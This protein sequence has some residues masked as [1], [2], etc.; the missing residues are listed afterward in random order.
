[1]FPIYTAVSIAA[2]ILSGVLL[3]K[4]DTARLIPYFQL[5]MIVAFLTFAY[6]QS[7]LSALVGFIFLG[8]SSGANATLPNAFWAEFYGTKHLG[9]IKAA[10]AAVM[11]LGSAV[12]PAITGILLDYDIALDAQYVAVSIFFGFSSVMMWIG[13]RRVSNSFVI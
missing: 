1:M 3:D 4:L 13:V 6:G 10:A 2:M 11:V 12:G 7:L 9:S 5:P 8:L